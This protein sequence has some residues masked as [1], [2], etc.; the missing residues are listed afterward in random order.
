MRAAMPS[1]RPL[2]CVSVRPRER[3]RA[4]C[5]PIFIMHYLQLQGLGI[6]LASSLSSRTRPLCPLLGNRPTDTVSSP[7]LFLS[8]IFLLPLSS[9]FFSF[10]A[11]PF[12]PSFFLSFFFCFSLVTH[13]YFD[14]I[15]S[16]VDREWYKNQSCLCLHFEYNK[17]KLVIIE[18]D[19]IY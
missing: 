11:D 10:L 19:Y 5:V 1:T 17:R 7:L 14:K 4:T 18:D 2:C 8:S 6:P 13:I 12:L 9:F 15:M 16:N 3:A